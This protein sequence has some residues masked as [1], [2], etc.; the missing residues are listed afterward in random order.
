MNY[1][2]TY[3]PIGIF[4]ERHQNIQAGARCMC[5]EEVYQNCADIVV[6]TSGTYMNMTNPCHHPICSRHP[7]CQ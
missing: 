4:G 1:D 7:M 5:P 3:S 2:W 6:D